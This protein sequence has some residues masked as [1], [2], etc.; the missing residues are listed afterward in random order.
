MNDSDKETLRD[1]FAGM[2]AMAFIMRGVP[3][4]AVPEQAYE[5]ADRLMDTRDPDVAGLPAIKKRKIK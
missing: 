3:D 4:D 2:C 1:M 5:M